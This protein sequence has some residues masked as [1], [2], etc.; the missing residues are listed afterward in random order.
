[1][2][3]ADL[4]R[5]TDPRTKEGRKAVVLKRWEELNPD[6]LHYQVVFAIGT[7]RAD[8]LDTVRDLLGRNG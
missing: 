4:D 6:V 1:M 2:P 5:A 3:G 7:L 8:A